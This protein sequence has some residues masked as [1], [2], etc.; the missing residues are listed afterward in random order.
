MIPNQSVASYIHSRRDDYNNKLTYSWEGLGHSQ[1]DVLRQIDFYK[2]SRF[3]DGDTD[4]DGNYLMFQNIVNTAAET[5]KTY[6]DIDQV[7]LELTAVGAKRIKSR[8]LNKENHKFM[9][10]IHMGQ[11]LNRMTDVR[12][13]YGGVLVRKRMEKGK[14]KLEVPDWKDIICN[15][16]DINRDAIIQRTVIAPIDLYQKVGIWDN[17]EE[18]IEAYNLHRHGSHTLPSEIIVYEIFGNLPE[19]FGKDN[20]A[21]SDKH[22]NKLVMAVGFKT[23]ELNQ[24][25]N[26]NSYDMVDAYYT[27]FESEVEESPFKYLPYRKLSGRTLG[28]G[29]IEAGFMAQMGVNRALYEE[30]ESMSVAGKVFL[31]TASEELDVESL[32]DAK[33]GT[34]V[35]HEINRPITNLNVT[36]SALPVWGNMIDRF[37]TQYNTET[38]VNPYTAGGDV[39]SRTPFKTGELVNQVSTKSFNKR[40][41]EMDLF[42]REIYQDWLFPY[43]IENISSQHILD[44]KFTKEELEEIDEVYA[45]KVV[46][47]QVAEYYSKTGKIPTEE[48]VDTAYD[49]VVRTLRGDGD[50]RKLAIPKDFFK[51]VNVEVKLNITNENMNK[52]AMMASLTNIYQVLLQNPQALQDEQLSAILNELLE[53]AGVSSVR[54]GRSTPSRKNT[55]AAELGAMS[56]SGSG[57]V[58]NAVQAQAN[59][60]V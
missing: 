50:R 22:V 51:D 24:A 13:D 57:A 37:Q 35:R 17:A 49:K 25:D 47:K 5:A 41:Q 16:S 9:E 42:L 21:V 4:E 7:D 31:Q 60:K 52:E 26:A 1:R 48:E 45:A 58:A 12:V 46:D 8:L 11:L 54:I 32:R 28:Q 36:P 3:L 10:E 40:K 53:Y 20:D 59:N 23:M 44:A 6:Q 56:G 14:L 34:I 18:V 15:T 43:F 30:T 39:P 2:S 19:N 29:V 33:S 38:S 27:V 55:I